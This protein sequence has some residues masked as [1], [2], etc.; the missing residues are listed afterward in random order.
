MFRH[1]RSWKS[2][3]IEDCPSPLMSG[4]GGK[5]TLARSAL[6]LTS[7]G[8]RPFEAQH[9][10]DRERDNDASFDKAHRQHDQIKRDEDS[11]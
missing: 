9:C 7:N 11:E 10:N 3:P 6:S 4:L 2:Q 5:Q 1:C 8:E